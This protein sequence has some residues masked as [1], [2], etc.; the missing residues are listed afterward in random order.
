MRTHSMQQAHSIVL[1]GR[2]G[3]LALP[4]AAI[5]TAERRACILFGDNTFF[6]YTQ[7]IFACKLHWL[8][9]L[10]EV[11]K[12]TFAASFS[13]GVLGFNG[14][15]VQCFAPQML[16]QQVR[17]CSLSLRKQLATERR[18]NCQAGSSL[19][20]CTSPQ[21]HPWSVSGPVQHVLSLRRQ[22]LEAIGHV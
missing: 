12:V 8:E 16:Q 18:Q 19:N 1:A 9:I 3:G 15:S 20:L 5:V 4:E 17:A 10:F 22:A 2:I 11:Y 14:G 13:W 7:S 6:A 21:W